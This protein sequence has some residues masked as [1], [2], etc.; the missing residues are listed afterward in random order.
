LP[1]EVEEA[2]ELVEQIADEE[3]A[4]EVLEVLTEEEITVEDIEQ[5]VQDEAFDTLTDEQVGAISVA[6]NDQKDEVK[7]A[8]EEEVD[9]FA[10]ATEEYV[11]AGSRVDVEDRRAIIAVQSAG[12][13]VA[14][15]AARPKPPAPPAPTAPGSAP[16]TGGPSRGS[17]SR[18]D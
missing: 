17:R 4:E 2:V 6:L 9:V 14:A 10:G 16:T 11:P 3:L 18:N 12:V 1:P 13:A 15:G 8:F 5:V 7:E